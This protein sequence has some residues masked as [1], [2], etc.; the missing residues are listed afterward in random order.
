MDSRFDRVYFV[1]LEPNSIDRVMQLCVDY[2]NWGEKGIKNERRY[3]EVTPDR[4][5][6]G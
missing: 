2:D 1:K 5:K 6:I 3:I 4:I